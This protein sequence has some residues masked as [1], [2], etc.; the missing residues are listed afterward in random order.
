LQ[1]HPAVA[2]K[3]HLSQLFRFAQPP[4]GRRFE[5]VKSDKLDGLNLSVEKL[6]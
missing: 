2:R 6:A 5:L 4:L 1:H 3:I